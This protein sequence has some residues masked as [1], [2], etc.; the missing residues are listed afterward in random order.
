MTLEAKTDS[1]KAEAESA[2]AMMK[3]FN[4]KFNNKIKF[5]T[6]IKSIQRKTRLGKENRRLY[7]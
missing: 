7:H 4:T 6:K 2:L 3:M 5:E 1:A